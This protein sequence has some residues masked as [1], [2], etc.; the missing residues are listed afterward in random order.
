MRRS[1]FRRISLVFFLSA[2]FA[3]TGA[4]AQTTGKRVF[5]TSASCEM[6]NLLSATECRNAHD[7]ALAELDEKSP[8]FAARAECEKHFTH[9]MIAGFAGKRVEFEPAMK[10]FEVNARSATDKTVTPVIEG[11]GSSLGFHARTALRADAGASHAM[12]EQSQARWTQA[13]KARAEAEAATAAHSRS[14]TGEPDFGA[15][16]RDSSGLASPAAAPQP[17]SEH[18]LAAAARRREEMRNAPT[19][20]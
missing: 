8:R 16:P 2:G 10:G 3:T 1:D 6:G 9:C 17:P 5:S 11:D 12:R 13:Q 15:A 20:Y 18:D 14:L 19:V 4:F 7:N